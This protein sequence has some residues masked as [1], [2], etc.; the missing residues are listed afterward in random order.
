MKNKLIIVGLIV[1]G[2]VGF[3]GTLAAA[4]YFANKVSTSVTNTVLQDK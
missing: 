2:M 3:F 1:L 4:M